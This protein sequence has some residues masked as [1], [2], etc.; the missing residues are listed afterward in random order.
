MGSDNPL[1]QHGLMNFHQHAWPI[2]RAGHPDAVL[3]VVGK[4]AEHLHTDDPRV[5]RAGWVA[6][7]DQEYRKAA[8]VINPTQAGTGLKGIKTVEAIC[9]GKAFVG[10]PNSIDGLETNG[11][12][13]YSS[14][15]RLE[16]LCG[17][18]ARS[19]TVRGQP[20]NA[21]APCL[22]VRPRQ[23]LN[24]THVCAACG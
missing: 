10:T 1:N 6:D 19:P 21:R 24:R 2:V 15:Q 8:V 17:G 13:P 22:A 9:R 3:R 7:F 5:Q 20:H 12:S 16:R 18:G 14:L 11:K 23:I 4:L